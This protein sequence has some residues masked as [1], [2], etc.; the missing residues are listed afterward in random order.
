M[1]K[2]SEEGEVKEME[3]QRIREIMRE[4]IGRVALKQTTHLTIPIDCPMAL[5][6]VRALHDSILNHTKL[7]TSKSTKRS[8]NSDQGV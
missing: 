4:E 2:Q 8:V 6:V 5:P 1:D 7:M 3:E